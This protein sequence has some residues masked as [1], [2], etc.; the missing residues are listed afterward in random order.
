MK[1]IFLFA[2]VTLFP[3]FAANAQYFQVDTARLNTAY[4]ELVDN[5][6]SMEKQEAFFNA[7]PNNWSEFITTYGFCSKDGYDLTMYSAA[8]EHIAAF[9]SKMSLINDTVYCRKLVNIAVGG[10]YGA[11][12]PNYFKTALHRTMQEKEGV[13]LYCI[14][15][16]RK[17]HCMQFWQF[18]WSCN[19]KS[20]D[21]EKEFV[22]L[23][24]LNAGKYPDMMKTMEIAFHYFYNGVNIDGGYLKGSGVYYDNNGQYLF[25]VLETEAEFPGGNKVLTEWI[26]SNMQYPKECVENKIEG[27]A[28]VRFVVKKDG[29]IDNVEILKS[30]RNSELDQEALRL[31]NDE[32]MPQWIPAK[33]FSESD[34]KYIK[35]DSRFVMPIV[36]KLNNV[37]TCTNPE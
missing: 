10:V 5:P 8:Y 31:M 1:K 32:D 28:F 16:L 18:Y 9:G 23:Y 3:A 37:P 4:R 24:E 7:F 6:D 14:S 15:K 33:Q 26:K 12:A 19:G 11:D 25:P 13:M 2:I 29:S 21:F 30:S 36:F 22:H 27:R 20:D 35:V 17:G 34:G